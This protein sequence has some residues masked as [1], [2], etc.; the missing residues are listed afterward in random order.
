M[1]RHVNS[2]SWPKY[3]HIRTY[4]HYAQLYHNYNPATTHPRRL[5]DDDV[6]V[7]ELAE[8]THSEERAEEEVSVCIEL[9]TGRVLSSQC[10]HLVQTL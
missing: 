9:S 4:I 2:L 3:I 5:G 1:N 7:E 6:E 8:H 10:T